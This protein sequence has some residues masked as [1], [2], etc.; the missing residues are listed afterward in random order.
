VLLSIS[1]GEGL[2][3]RTLA[4]LKSRL[5]DRFGADLLDIRL[6]GSYA[7][8]EADE[9][10]DV[11]VFVLLRTAGWPERK[12]VLDIAGDL[13]AESGLLISPT[14]FDL[15]RHQEWRRQERPLVMDIEREGVPL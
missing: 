15:V 12:A 8:G 4:E 14:V 7:R 5:T 3:A 6:F 13:F 11:D 1:M 10:S 2:L 9:D